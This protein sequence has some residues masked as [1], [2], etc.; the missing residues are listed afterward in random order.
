MARFK[1]ISL[2]GDER[3]LTLRF[4]DDDPL[5]AFVDPMK[6]EEIRGALGCESL[7]DIRARAAEDG[8]TVHAFVHERLA[9]IAERREEFGPWTGWPAGTLEK[10]EAV[11]ALVHE[12]RPRVVLDPFAGRASYP[13]AAAQASPAPRVFY[14]EISRMFRFVA[15]TRVRAL[16][17]HGEARQEVA[18]EL[19]A[20]APRL[21]RALAAAEPAEMRGRAPIEDEADATFL[22]RVRTIADELSTHA[23]ALA[24][25]ALVEV[26]L[27][28]G[29]LPPRA[30]FVELLRAEFRKA[31]EFLA[32]ETPLESLPTLLADDA[33]ALD[34][35]RP[36]AIDCVIT[37][38]PSLNFASY[39]NAVANWFLGLTRRPASR[40]LSP[41][42][43]LAQLPP[44]LGSRGARVA[45]RIRAD[46]DAILRADERV[47]RIA[48][49]Y[50]RDM[51]KAFHAID[52]HLTPRS[53]YGLVVRPSTIAGVAVDT[54]GHLT[55]MLETFGFVADAGE[56]GI[57]VLR[58]RA[59]AGD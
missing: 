33:R 26:L 12:L 8:V 11:R 56:N 16:T 38:P 37:N 7:A 57:L 41:A 58:R 39:S 49:N 2:R 27:R 52:T 21:E 59:A 44:L 23:G 20:L 30:Q 9:E 51:A 42:D 4:A 29:A 14:C 10:S 17:L 19:G 1:S 43:A 36:L 3:R 34:R 45:S 25:C 13:I 28:T 22:A 55:S 31:A 18:A 54:P 47:G 24:A 15:E 5:F 32:R 40:L 46:V 48:A 35:L 6:S 50:F 53:T